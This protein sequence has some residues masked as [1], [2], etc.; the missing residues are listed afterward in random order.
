M[1]ISEKELKL[2]IVE[3][4][5]EQELEEGA[6]DFLSG[7]A[8]KLGADIEKTVT[9]GVAKAQKYGKDL[10]RAGQSKSM[11]RDL[12][13]LGARIESIINKASASGDLELLSRLDEFLRTLAND[14][15]ETFEDVLDKATDP[16]Q[17]DADEAPAPSSA[18]PGP[19]D[20]AAA[21]RQRAIDLALGN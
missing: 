11:G 15:E 21:T 14:I 10:K 8:D 19:T 17:P 2:V 16:N 9:T 3:A 20:S 13:S 12:K 4:L 18:T 7:I 6:L 1:K 5:Q